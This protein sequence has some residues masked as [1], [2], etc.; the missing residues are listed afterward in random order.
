LAHKFPFG[1]QI[2]FWHINFLLAHK[3]PLT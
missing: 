1:T 2:F 3:C